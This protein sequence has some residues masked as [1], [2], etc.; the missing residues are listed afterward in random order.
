[1]QIA[2]IVIPNLNGMEFLGPCLDSLMQQSR[3]DF[4]VILV[5]NGSQD[6]SV[7]FVETHYPE[8]ILRQFEQ[9]EGFCRAV[10]EG[11]RMADTPY[12]ILLNNDTI[13]D[14]SFVEEMVR[15][16]ETTGAFSCAAKLVRMYE[17]ERMD[18]AGDF[19]CA[20]GWAFALGKGKPAER[21]D[22]QRE[23]FSSCA[24]AA[25]YR[26]DVFDSI[27][28]FD[29]VHFAYLEDTDVAYRARIAGYRNYYA[30]KAI[31]RHVG[32]ATSGSVYNDFKIRYSSRNNIYMIYKNMPWLQILLNFPFLLAG[33]LIK[34]VFFAGKGYLREYVTGLGT[35][36]ALCHRDKK[37]RFQWKNLKAY[38]RIQ[39]ELWLNVFRRLTDV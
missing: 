27:G 6:G 9:N 4:S 33:F 19:Y 26:R 10:N 25:I 17:P 28:L 3:Q 23:I 7:E 36:I 34:M 30:P 12:V 13:C 37:V 21:Y 31:V 14:E 18:N 22:R 20:L 39:L 32:S 11:I 15:A 2:T 29:E 5:D 24:A 1:M 38:I 16:I 35:G 8:V